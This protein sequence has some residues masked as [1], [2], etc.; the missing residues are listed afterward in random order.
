MNRHLSVWI[1]RLLFIV[2]ATCL[3]AYAF[4]TVDARRYQAEQTAAFAA[5]EAA[6]KAPAARPRP[7]EKRSASAAM[8]S[9]ELVETGTLLGMLDVPR[10]KLSAPVV[11]GDDDSTLSKAVGH[12]P[13]TPLPWHEGNSAV[14][15]HRDTLFR[16]LKDIAVG[17]EI[18]F[19]TPTGDL[20]YRVTRTSIVNPDDVSVLDP[21]SRNMITLITCYPFYYVGHAPKRFIVHAERE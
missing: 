9:T 11:Q 10:L 15:A 6:E 4:A 3:G 13:D 21:G 7:E 12:L 17:D 5:S 2:G 14:A 19:R 1:E 16:P 8:P 20:H 18:L